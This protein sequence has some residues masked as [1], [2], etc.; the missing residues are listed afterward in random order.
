VYAKIMK[1]VENYPPGLKESLVK[2]NQVSTKFKPQPAVGSS[3]LNPS[4]LGG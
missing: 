3:Y 2:Y 4:Y 1:Y